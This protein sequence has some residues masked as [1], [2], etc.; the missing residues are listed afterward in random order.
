M[1]AD[2]TFRELMRRVRAGDEQ[3]AA[4][5]LA[6]YGPEIRRAI[7]VHL[8]NPRLNPILESVDIFQS[9]LASF[10]AKLAAG[11]YDLD[12][13]DQ[14]IGLLVTMARHKII[15]YARKPD[16]RRTT[17][18]DT[19]LWQSLAGPDGCPDQLLAHQ[20]LLAQVWARLSDA[21]ARLARLRADGRSWEEIAAECGG[22]ADGVRKQLAR[23]LDRVGREL[24]IGK[25]GHE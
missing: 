3:A 24:G 9:V 21:E 5:L 23:A 7:R 6:L 13:P 10:F 22:T 18:Q 11:A 14:L 2:P 12:R 1:A 25:N 16:Q 8:T 17:T 4:E 15:D 20:E 19:D